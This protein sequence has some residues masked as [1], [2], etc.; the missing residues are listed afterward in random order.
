MESTGK[1][2]NGLN[3]MV[4]IKCPKCKSKLE[5][6][7]YKKEDDNKTAV[8]CSNEKCLYHTNPLIGLDRTTSE[9]Y[10]SESII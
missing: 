9:V 8:F 2:T 7:D 5:I 1:G 3:I 10:I 4:N 6:S